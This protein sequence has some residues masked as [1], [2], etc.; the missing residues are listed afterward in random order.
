MD[1][2]RS[3]MKPSNISPSIL[4]SDT[5]TTA[6][7][8]F[9]WWTRC[10]VS[11]DGKEGTEIIPSL[12]LQV[13]YQT[14]SQVDTTL[15]ETSKLYPILLSSGLK[16]EQ[17][18]AIWTFAN[19]CIPGQLTKEELFLA[20][21]LIALAQKR[22]SSFAFN[23][24]FSLNSPPVPELSLV[25][26]SHLLNENNNHLTSSGESSASYNQLDDDEFT[27][28]TSCSIS[29]VREMDQVTVPSVQTKDQRVNSTDKY[30]VFRELVDGNNE[31]T[32]HK[33]IRRQ[34]L[35][36][37]KAFLQKSFNTLIVNH[38]EECTLEALHHPRGKQFI[39]DLALI[40]TI[41]LRAAKQCT[42][43]DLILI[44]DE[45]E[46]LWT[47]LAT[48]FKRSGHLPVTCDTDII[49]EASASSCEIC[50]G[51]DS[52]L[53][54]VRGTFYHEECFNLWISCIGTQLPTKAQV[55]KV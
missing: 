28:F 10:A 15:C 55:A 20:L 22:N 23:E 46:R 45:I 47:S 9:P 48:L 11:S 34:C 24:V 18:G 7:E 26:K 51:K 1:Q 17:L 13:W 27:D 8:S 38:G 37:C 19:R 53:T 6:S 42:S 3:T 5:K 29:S 16:M 4:S 36:Q 39:D 32:D 30:Q 49:E 35:L 14:Q 12:Y 21:A 40:H 33:E 25:D 43:V 31:S 2:G 41:S 50:G 44:H 52:T 54:L